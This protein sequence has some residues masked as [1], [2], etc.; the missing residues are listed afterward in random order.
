[1]TLNPTLNE[2][3][4][5]ARFAKPSLG[6]ALWQLINTLPLFALLWALMVWTVNMEWSYVWTLLLALPAAGLFVRMFIIQHDCGHGS[7]FASQRANQWLGA[8]LGLITLFPFGYWKKTHAVHHGTSG[9]LDRRE[10]G[11]VRTLTLAEY[12]ARSR[13]GRFCYRFYRSMPVLLGLGPTFQFVIKHRLPFDLPLS[14]KKE[15]ASVLLN[16]LMLL[17]AATACGVLLGWHMMLLVH[18]PV[19][20]IAGAIGVWLFYVQHT[21]AGAYW[22]RRKDWSS[23]Q[24]AIAGSSFYDL[25]R[26]VHWFT[27]NIGYHHIHHLAP[28]IPNYRLRAAFDSSPLL[29]RAPSLT[30]RTSL[31]CARM[32]LWDEER[33]QMIGFPA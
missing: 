28:R 23:H 12:R 25:P 1:M 30:L 14:W 2:R 6:R 11:D 24:A 20:L 22:A 17:I 33:Q 27:G 8:C 19:V 13:W 15:W 29:Q 4:L 5:C 18:L 16:N 21:F 10:F 26:V 31:A 3:Q 7:Y 32:K 9:N